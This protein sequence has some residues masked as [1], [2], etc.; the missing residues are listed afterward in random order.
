VPAHLRGWQLNSGDK[1]LSANC[2]PYVQTVEFGDASRAATRAGAVSAKVA[3]FY[4][5]A[6][7]TPFAGTYRVVPVPAALNRRLANVLGGP[8][9]PFSNQVCLASLVMPIGG[10]PEVI[11]RSTDGRYWLIAVPLGACSERNAKAQ[12]LIDQVLGASPA[13]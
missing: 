13:G 2:G 12:A 10:F 5:C 7:K 4:V 8:D 3:Y 1:A 11:V 6:P 9:R